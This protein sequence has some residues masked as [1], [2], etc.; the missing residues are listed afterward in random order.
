M[1]L[2]ILYLHEVTNCCILKLQPMSINLKFK[3]CLFVE[4]CTGRFV[5]IH[6]F[7]NC[8]LHIQ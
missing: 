3:R 2:S 5:C 1:D 4:T 6:V 7:A 8:L